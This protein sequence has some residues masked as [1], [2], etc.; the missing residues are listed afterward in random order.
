MKALR[1]FLFWLKTSRKFQQIARRECGSDYYNNRHEIKHHVRLRV[2]AVVRGFHAGSQEWQLRFDLR[3]ITGR[4]QL[5]FGL[6]RKCDQGEISATDPRLSR[7]A[8][9]ARAIWP[10]RIGAGDKSAGAV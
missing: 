8:R 9:M 1:K 4:D 5:L 6:G 2:A 7:S 3:R 10:H